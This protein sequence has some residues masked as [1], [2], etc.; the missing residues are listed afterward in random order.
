IVVSLVYGSDWDI[1]AAALLV[2][3][4]CGSDWDITAA[5]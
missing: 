4:C 5:I 2:V 1:T 3:C